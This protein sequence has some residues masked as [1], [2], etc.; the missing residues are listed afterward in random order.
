[1]RLLRL[2]LTW[3]VVAEIA[4]VAALGAE[5]WHVLGARVTAARSTVSA[6]ELGVLPAVGIPL[7]ATPTPRP[8][9]A[10]ATPTP[11]R[12]GP[13]PGLGAS[14]AFLGRE[15]KAINHDQSAWERSEWT[16]IQA[17]LGFARAYVEQ[18]VLPGVRA[19]EE[20]G[21]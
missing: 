21:R 17:V 16:I 6:S 11:R 15:L 8:A 1:M 4:V 14:P 13:T 2:P 10:L 18:V 19:A 12:A 5:A 7:L 9:L 3:L 20:G